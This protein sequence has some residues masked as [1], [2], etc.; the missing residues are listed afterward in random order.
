MDVALAIKSAAFAE[1]V[2]IT[3]QA[4]YVREF[5]MSTVALLG[6]KVC[7]HRQRA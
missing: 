4:R 3:S 6:R 7:L 5:K 1:S 2:Y